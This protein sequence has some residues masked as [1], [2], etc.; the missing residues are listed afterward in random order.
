MTGWGSSA[1]AVWDGFK[2]IKHQ[3]DGKY[4]FTREVQD[5]IVDICGGKSHM[6][7]MTEGGRVY[8]SG[9]TLYRNLSESRSNPENNEDYPFEIRMPDE[10]KAT[11]IFTCEKYLNVFVTATKGDIS[12]TFAVGAD[13]KLIGDGKDNST[14]SFVPMDLPEGVYMTKITC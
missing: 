7:V 6:I 12:K 14:S 4:Y 13:S 11:A 9:Y 5:K 8:A 3:E 10:Y 2:E 1:S